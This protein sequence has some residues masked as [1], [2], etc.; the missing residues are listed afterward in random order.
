MFEGSGIFGGYTFPLMVDT[1]QMF[2]TF[3]LLRKRFG[4]TFPP[5]TKRL[6]LMVETLERFTTL[7]FITFLRLL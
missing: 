5:L 6:P 7:M 2:G 3:K 4:L 1:P